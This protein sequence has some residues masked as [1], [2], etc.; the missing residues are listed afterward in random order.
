MNNNQKVKVFLVIIMLIYLVYQV[1]DAY[2]FY[3]NPTA[4]ISNISVGYRVNATIFKSSKIPLENST[5]IVVCGSLDTSVSEYM[6]ILIVKT[7]DGKTLGTNSS[8]KAIDSGPFCVDINLLERLNN[9]HYTILIIDE[10]V[11][12][13]QIDIEIID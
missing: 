13:D 3:N 7:I 4:S 10:R 1:Y 11:I 2:Q 12:V 8:D 5:N 9:G 6:E